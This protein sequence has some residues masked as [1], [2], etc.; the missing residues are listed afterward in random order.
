MGDHLDRETSVSV[1]LTD[2]GIKAKAKSR[3]VAAIDRFGGNL[4]ELVNSPM[5]RRISR[6][7]AISAGEV[8]LVE[9]VTKFG[10]DKLKR[11]PEFAEQ[12]AEKFFE[13]VFIKQDNKNAV[14]FEA[15]ED[16]RHDP[17]SDAEMEAGEAQ[18]DEQ[19]LGRLERFSEEATTDKLRQKWGRVLSA[20]V[21][22]PGTFT[23]KVLRIVDEID[24]ETAILFERLCASRFING[25]PRCLVGDLS[26]AEISRLTMSGL[27]LD[28]GLTGHLYQFHSAINSL[29]ED[30]WL[31]SNKEYAISIPKGTAIP[32][33]QTNKVIKLSDK[34]PAIPV[35]LLTDAGASIAEI[36]PSNTTLSFSRCAAC[37]RDALPEAVVTLY[38]AGANG[39]FRP[40]G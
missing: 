34:L 31:I 33:G 12:V 30:V 18:L 1:A 40:I 36:F 19:F 23:L 32:D 26:F 3:L 7:R 8:K 15:L 29:G 22:K 5:E 16:L 17:P 25:L 24:P 39:E 37:L 4:M 28:P 20:E 9:A 13:G 11:E 2:T 27:L 38:Q 35:Y 10:I 14:L 6:Q 21:R